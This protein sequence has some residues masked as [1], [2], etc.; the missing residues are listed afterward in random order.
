MRLL[1]NRGRGARWSWKENI[2]CLHRKPRSP[3]EDNN[4]WGRGQMHYGLEQQKIQT[5]VLGHSLIRS[6]VRSHR[7]LIC[8]LRT[9]CF[10]RALRCAHSFARSLTL[11]TPSLWESEFFMSHNDLVL[12][13][14][15][16]SGP[17]FCRLWLWFDLPFLQKRKNTSKKVERKKE[18][19]R[20]RRR[21]ICKRN[22]PCHR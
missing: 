21:N 10:A 16:P 3:R 12:S 7:S 15:G 18:K 19:K 1:P 20:E 4:C 13:H 11:L 5:A 9:A 2:S 22:I 6:L 17:R 14:S 8:L